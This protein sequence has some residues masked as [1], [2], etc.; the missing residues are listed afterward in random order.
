VQLAIYN[1]WGVKIYASSGYSN[2][3]RGDGL[4]DGVYY[5]VLKVSSEGG[6]E[7]VGNFVLLR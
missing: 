5:Y 3:F 7:V 1:R 2:D 6:K 4:A